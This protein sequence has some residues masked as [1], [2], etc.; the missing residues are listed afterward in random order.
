MMSNLQADHRLNGQRFQRMR[1]LPVFSLVAMVYALFLS[2]GCEQSQEQ[3]I[4]RN[5]E[6]LIERNQLDSAYNQLDELYRF[7]PKAFEARQLQIVILLKRDQIEKAID[8]YND[9]RARTAP[10]TFLNETVRDPDPRVRAGIS[11]LIART[12]PSNRS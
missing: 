9:L 11:V 10:V 7:D 12:K 6:S 5:A 4:L 2:S 3:R 1:L 8:I